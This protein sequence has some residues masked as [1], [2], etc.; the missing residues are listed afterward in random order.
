MYVGAILGAEERLTHPRLCAENL[1]TK[2]PMNDTRAIEE[3][4]RLFKIKPRPPIIADEQ[5]AVLENMQRLR[6]ER[7]ERKSRRQG[8][9]S[10]KILSER[11]PNGKHT[12]MTIEVSYTDYQPVLANLTAA[13]RPFAELAKG[14]KVVATVPLLQTFLAVAIKPGPD[15]ERYSESCRRTEWHHEPTAGGSERHRAGRRSGTRAS[16]SADQS[17]GSPAHVELPVVKRRG[18][19]PDEYRGDDAKGDGAGGLTSLRW[20]TSTNL[21]EKV[22]RFS[23]IL[24]LA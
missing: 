10:T 8:E 7:L 21:D 11:V 23:G 16:R 3:A 4:N 14:T 15:R 12:T 9:L 1:S 20:A 22:V 24:S 2:I 18:P 19:G 17:Y 13:L 6:R 5:R